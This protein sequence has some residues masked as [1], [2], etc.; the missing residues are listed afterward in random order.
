MKQSRLYLQMQLC[1]FTT[2]FCPTSVLASAEWEMP[3]ICA[4]PVTIARNSV[5]ISNNCSLRSTAG[6]TD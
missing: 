1:K 5:S 4:A 6:L 3:G 2:L